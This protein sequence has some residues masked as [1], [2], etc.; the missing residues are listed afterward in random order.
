MSQTRTL[1]SC[2]S[3]GIFIYVLLI[4]TVCPFVKKSMAPLRVLP[5]MYSKGSLDFMYLDPIPESAS[6]AQLRVST[7]ENRTGKLAGRLSSLQRRMAPGAPECWLLPSK[8]S[9]WWSSVVLLGVSLHLNFP[10]ILRTGEALSVDF[11][12]QW[13]EFILLKEEKRPLVLSS[14]IRRIHL[15]RITKP[16]SKP[17]VLTLLTLWY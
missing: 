7:G 12:P 6:E 15:M 3:R 17:V 10:Q 4:P 1:C 8:Q 14:F 2:S 11:V 9:T 16:S 13:I 5:E